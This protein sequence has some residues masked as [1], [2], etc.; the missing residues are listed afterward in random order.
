M[1]KGFTLLELLIVII[2]LGVLATLGFTQ[3]G[4]M[5]ERSRGAE[6]RAICGDIRKMAIAYRMDNGSI[7]P[8]AANLGLVNIGTAT[9]M[10]PNTCA[11]THYFSYTVTSSTDPT[12]VITATRCAG[13]NGKQPGGA[14][15]TLTLTSNITGGTDTW[16]GTGSY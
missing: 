16:G 12:L 5:I 13:T 11:V 1:K 10:I 7:G 15:L 9:D 8:V 14:G 2:I 3:Y 4:R 6:A